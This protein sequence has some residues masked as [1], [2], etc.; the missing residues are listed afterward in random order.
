MSEIY[1]FNKHE[2]NEKN[3]KNAAFSFLKNIR[4]GTE[5][6][7]GERNSP[8][9]D[10]SSYSRDNSYSTKESD[11]ERDDDKSTTTSKPKFFIHEDGSDNES[12]SSKEQTTFLQNAFTEITSENNKRNDLLKVNNNNNV[13]SNNTNEVSSI[14]DKPKKNMSSVVTMPG[15]NFKTLCS[16]QEVLSSTLAYLPSFG[17]GRMPYWNNSNCNNRRLQKTQGRN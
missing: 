2:N 7:N 17:S 8:V 11:Y 9:L 12:N 6:S 4:L 1:K 13:Y 3:R 15:Y 14:T 10:K 16:R 5:S